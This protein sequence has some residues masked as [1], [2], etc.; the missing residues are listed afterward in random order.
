MLIESGWRGGGNLRAWCGGEALSRDL[1][2]AL[3]A[4]VAELW[5][6]Y[7]PTEATIWSTAA[8]IESGT[9]PIPIGRPIENTRVYVADREGE[10]SPI[11]IPGEILIA[12][13]GV[14]KGYHGRPEMTAERFMPDRFVPQGGERLYRTGDLGKW[15]ADGLL[16]HLGRM[17]D[18]VKVRG[19]RI[20]PGEI[21]TM[22]RQH[23]AVAQAVVAAREVSPGDS[24]LVA[25][26]VYTG[27]EVT[28][29]E[30][31]ENLRLQLPDYMVPAVFV[32]I[33]KIPL[34][35]NGKVNREALPDPFA[36]EVRLAGEY[37]APA[38]GVE[39]LIA[40]IWRD[41]LKVG[42]VSASDNFFE[43]GGH[44]LL[45][46][47]VAILVKKRTGQRLDP[48]TLYFQNLRQIAAVVAHGRA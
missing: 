41:L 32:S 39:E 36:G 7:G 1:A 15:G 19:F 26:V 34:T 24:R 3:L 14:A 45:A 9:A 21:E 5:N 13:E 48:R 4:R 8:Q 31:R 35:P 27:E 2:D 25:Y 16:Y 22:L 43:L 29:S 40:G 12:G 10:L 28:V 37:V 17:D 11:G 46:L 20:E 18:Q 42:N 33:D 6:L 47:K 38:A 23:S 44:S 30:L